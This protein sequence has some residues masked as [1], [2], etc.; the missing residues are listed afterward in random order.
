MIGSWCNI[1]QIVF[2]DFRTSSSSL[3]QGPEDMF[4]LFENVPLSLS[5]S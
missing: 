3:D 1:L 4:V 2:R 5:L